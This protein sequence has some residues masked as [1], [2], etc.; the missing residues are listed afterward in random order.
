MRLERSD[1]IETF[2]IMKGM[3]DVNRDIFK[4]DDSSRREHNQQLLKKIQT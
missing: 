1:L 4:Q 3:S 2:R